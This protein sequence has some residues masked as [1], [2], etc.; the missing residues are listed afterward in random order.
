MDHSKDYLDKI[1]KAFM[2]KD[3]QWMFHVQ[4]LLKVGAWLAVNFYHKSTA[5][6]K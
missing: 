2:E 1:P 5:G 6:S 3:L 4:A